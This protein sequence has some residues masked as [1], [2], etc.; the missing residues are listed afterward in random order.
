M[1]CDPGHCTPSDNPRFQ[2]TCGRC[3]RPILTVAPDPT[4]RRNLD[5]EREFTEHAAKGV[6]DPSVLI[7]HSEARAATLSDAYVSDPMLVQGG[8]D[9]AREMREEL[10]DS[11]V[12]GCW[13]GEERQAAGDDEGAHRAMQALRHI[14]LAYNLLLDED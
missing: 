9:L 13:L 7:A 14:I 8:K 12:Y 10:A 3:G 2:N 11:R 4:R 5:F 6:A 1:T